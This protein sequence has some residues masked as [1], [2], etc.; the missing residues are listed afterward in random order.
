LPEMV[1]RRSGRIINIASR[2]GTEVT[3]NLSAYGVGKA[4][5]IRLTAHIAAEGREHGISAFAIEPGTVF[6]ELAAGTVASPD[7]Q[8]WLPGMLAALQQIRDRDDPAVGLARCGQICLD[9]ASG[10]YDAL[11]GMYLTP[12]D[13]LAGLLRRRA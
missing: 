11:S 12:Q 4:T 10:R 2:G 6:T 1:R 7:A 3:P 5:Q 13:D 9:L 8:R